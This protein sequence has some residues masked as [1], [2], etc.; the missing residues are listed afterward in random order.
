[1]RSLGLY[2][3]NQGS[4]SVLRE[5]GIRLIVYIDDMLIMAEMKTRLK[6][7][8]AGTVY[9]LGFVVNSPSRCCS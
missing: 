2:Q 4:D 3:D 5:I 7:H 8:I 6:D 1:M 9:L